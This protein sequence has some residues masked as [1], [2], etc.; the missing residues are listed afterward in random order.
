M[1]LKNMY[2]YK[3]M[4]IKT[5]YIHIYIYTYIHI[6]IYMYKQYI[7]KQY[8]Y[9]Q[10]HT[11]THTHTNRM[12]GRLEPKEHAVVRRG[13]K[14]EVEGPLTKTNSQKS[15]PKYIFEIESLN[16][17]RLRICIH[18]CL[19][20]VSRSLLLL[21]RSISRSLSTLMHTS[22]M[23]VIVGLFYSCTGSLSAL[24]ILVL[25]VNLC[26][27]IYVYMQII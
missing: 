19:A 22:S 11:H 10:T 16:R 26:I 20:N 1:V 9:I 14:R 21:N 15:A 25:Y 12:A 13:S 18:L 6:Y 5:V 2:I 7:Y 23:L 17:G 8:I 4:Y 24:E 27:C 3:Y